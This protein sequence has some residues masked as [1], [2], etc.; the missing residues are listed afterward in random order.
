MPYV[1]IPD[2]GLHGTIAKIVGKMMGGVMSKVIQNSTNITNSLNRKGCPTGP[3]TD[4][5]RKKLNQNQKLIF[6]FFNLEGFFFKKSSH[7][8]FLLPELDRT[9]FS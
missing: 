9:E 7:P 5:L 1:N 4:R 8:F 2:S 6:Y 3:E